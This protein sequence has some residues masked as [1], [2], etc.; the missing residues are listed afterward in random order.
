MYQ[1]AQHVFYQPSGK[2]NAIFLIN[3]SRKKILLTVTHEISAELFRMWNK[4]H[5]MSRTVVMET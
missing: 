1:V 5:S 4:K 3:K 2:T